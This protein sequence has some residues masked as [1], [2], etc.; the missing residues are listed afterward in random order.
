VIWRV[1]PLGPVHERSHV[2]VALPESACEGVLLDA[3]CATVPGGCV[4]ASARLAPVERPHRN[5]VAVT[6]LLT[7]RFILGFRTE[8]LRVV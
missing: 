4:C 5:V 6:H 7:R 3:T 1:F 2:P 8:P